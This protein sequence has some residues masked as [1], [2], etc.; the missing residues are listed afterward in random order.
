LGTKKRKLKKPYRV[1]KGFYRGMVA[2]SAT[3]VVLYIAMTMAIRPPDIAQAVGT[4]T[5][6]QT[7]N[8][9]AEQTSSP[10]INTE[11]D[12]T[13]TRKEKCYTFLLAASDDGNG[14]ADTI[15]V[16]TYDVPNKKIGL[17]SIPRD[18]VVKTTRKMPKINAAYA[19]GV[20]TLRD[21]VSKLVGI[22]ID[23]YLTVDMKAFVELVDAVG[24]VDFDVPVEMYYHDPD[25]D[26]SIRYM[27]GMQH[28]SGQ[29]AL[30][31]VRFRKNGDGTGYPDSDIGRTRTQQM[32]LAT[33]AGKV[34]DWNSIS[35]MKQYLNIF[36][37]YAKTDLSVRDMAYFATE[38]MKLDLDSAL[39]GATLPGDG[40]KNYKGYK[41]CYALDQAASLAILNQNVNPYT[42]PLTLQDVGFVT[43][44]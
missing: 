43:L 9:T 10:D 28:L 42:T 35:R 40:T 8:N 25:Q 7:T 18:T 27:P 34:T 41:W 30:E 11:K 24:G 13:K 3:I 20:E 32:M 2:I 36:N 6:N 31:V 37:K 26:L 12:G 33:L 21:E 4:Q 29:Q 1:M 5:D 14:N 39:A 15:M 22:P 17:V 19:Q 38:G 16:M 23:F 44:N